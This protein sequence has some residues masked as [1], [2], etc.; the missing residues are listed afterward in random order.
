MNCPNSNSKASKKENFS[1]FFHSDSKGV[2]D[3]YHIGEGNLFWL[4]LSGML[5]SSENILTVTPRNKA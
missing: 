1:T 4:L 2:D 5:I 3:V